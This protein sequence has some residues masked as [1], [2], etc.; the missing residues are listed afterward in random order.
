[1]LRPW[2]EEHPGVLEE[3]LKALDAAGY[4]YTRDSALQ[5]AGRIVLTVKFP[6][7][8]D[9]HDLMVVFPDFYPYFQF[10]IIAPPSFPK[11]LHKDPYHGLLC[12]LKDP[13][14]KWET[15]DTV[16]SILDTNV[17]G[18]VKAHQH[19]DDAESIEAHEGAQATG[20]FR[21]L[22]NTVVFTG[23][24]DIP[25]DHTYGHLLIGLEP[26]IKPNE[27]IRGAVLEVQDE[28]KNILVKIDPV[29]EERYSHSHKI[30][31]RW[32]RLPKPP[33]SDAENAI[34]DEAIQLWSEI[35]RP[36]LNNGPDI[37]GLL[38]PEEVEYKKP[39]QENWVF[40]VRRKVKPPHD[41]HTQIQTYLARADRA[42]RENNYARVSRLAPI[43]NKKVLVV[44]LGAIGSICAWQLARAGVGHMHLLDYDHLQLGNSPRW[45][46]GWDASGYYKADIL[47]RYLERQYP[48]VKITMD[49]HKIGEANYSPEDRRDIEVIENALTGVDLVLDATA[50]KCV[51]HFLSDL[52]RK[53]GVPYLWATG[54]PG[55]RGGAVGRIIP[56]RTEG[57]WKCYQHW[58]FDGTIKTPAQENVPDIQ[59]VGCFHPTF[60]GTGFDMDHIAL[61]AVRLAVSTLCANNEGAYPDFGWDVGIVDLWGEDGMP[62]APEWSTHPLQRHPK[63]DCDA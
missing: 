2:F 56:G 10:Q 51:S 31:G 41:K 45:L 1:M 57:C 60:T 59:P 23:D 38:F 18:I 54:T 34:F 52:A 55:S 30:L 26:G 15:S 32:V 11:G 47:K 7:G 27:I 36:K 40:V 16:A 21:Y 37:V 22:L 63:C 35:A 4:K 44:G 25:K 3:E 13:Q 17:R 14:Q 9:V 5:E 53:R 12:L 58:L 48:F 33:A 46:F 50:E 28:R 24:W 62:I 6:I 61:A 39:H 20:Y 8:E 42:S 19:P 29:L 49:V 43:E